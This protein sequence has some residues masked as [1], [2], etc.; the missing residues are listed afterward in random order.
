MLEDEVLS[1]IL[2]MKDVSQIPLK[3]YKKLITQKLKLD[4]LGIFP[5]KDYFGELTLSLN[6]SDNKDSTVLVL[7]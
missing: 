2:N 5:D 1:I 3:Q 7:I 6:I 4:L